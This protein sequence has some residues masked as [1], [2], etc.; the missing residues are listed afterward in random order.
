MTLPNR[1]PDPHGTNAAK[2][3][4]NGYVTVQMTMVEALK[5]KL[6]VVVE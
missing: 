6:E 2:T 4:R 1:G 3:A 5:T